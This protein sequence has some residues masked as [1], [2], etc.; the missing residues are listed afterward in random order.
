MLQ[1]TT[2]CGLAAGCFGPPPG[3]E[4]CLVNNC[5]VGNC[6]DFEE[7][8]D[9]LDCMSSCEDDAACADACIETTSPTFQPP[10]EN[11]L[12][13]GIDA[14]CFAPFC[15]DG[16]CGPD[17]AFETCPDDCVNEFVFYGVLIEDSWDGV[18]NPD[19]NSS[20]ADI[21]AVELLSCANDD[22][23]S[24]ETVAWFQNASAQIGTEGGCTN[25]FI[26]PFEAVGPCGCELDQ[27]V[28]LQGGWLAG[29]FGDVAIVSGLVVRVYEYGTSSN[30][31]EDPYT[32]SL[33]NDP[34]CMDDPSVEGC[35]TLLGT[36]VDVADFPVPVP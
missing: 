26:N 3:P 13:C 22:P 35:T 32:V 28:S 23:D 14:G 18:C 6:Q 4:E 16:T 12:V 17:E 7:C 15:G 30:G 8:A 10:L 19:Y 31:T 11:L 25:D 9:A 27:W 5:D 29:D 2:L 24:C 21:S 20:G 34:S 33:I 1:E 36:T